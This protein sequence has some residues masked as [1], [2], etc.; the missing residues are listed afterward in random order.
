M[1]Y[2]GYWPYDG[3]FPDG[4][5]WHF[6]GIGDLTPYDPGIYYG[7]AFFSY[8]GDDGYRGDFNTYRAGFERLNF[9]MFR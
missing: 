5:Y 9:S 1:D 4:T 3:A 8:D 7:N 2:F 6:G